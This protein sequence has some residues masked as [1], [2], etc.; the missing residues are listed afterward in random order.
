VANLHSAS[1]YGWIG[2]AYSLASAASAPI[3]AKISDIWGR[4]PIMLAAVILFFFSSMIC[5]LST[6]MNMLIAGRALQGVAAGGLGNMVNI[7]ISDLFSLR[8]R[9]LYFA[10]MHVM[11][12]L[13]GGVGP[14]LGG[15]FTELTS[16]RWCFW[17]N[18]P[19]SGTTFILLL[20]F[21]DV[22]N[23]KTK[24]LD[25]IKAVDWFGSLSILGLCLMTLLG[26]NFGGTTFPWNSPK[27]ICLIVFGLFM[28]IFFIFS[29]KR[30]ARYPLMPLSLFKNPSNVATFILSFAHGFVSTAILQLSYK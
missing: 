3:W 4:K 14:I 29:E 18:L 15:A 5:A 13:A 2:G 23:P 17:I 28:F 6:S 22:H 1:G 25:G 20:T 16:W 21:L 27:V 9:G 12:A 7:V 30:L 24:I 26:L 19:V 8:D 10:V 11:W